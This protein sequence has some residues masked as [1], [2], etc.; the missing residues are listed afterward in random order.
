MHLH[1]REMWIEFLDPDS[2]APGGPGD[3]GEVVVTQLGERAMPLLRYAPG[4]VFR[5][6]GEPCTCGDPSPRIAFVGQVGGIRKIKGVLVHPAQ[7][8][9]ALSAFPELGNFQITV[10]HPA[11]ARYDR[12]VIRIA[13]DTPSPD[14]AARVRERLKANV[15]IQMDV[16]LVPS[17]QM[18][19]NSEPVL[20]LRHEGTRDR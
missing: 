1:A 8:K 4:D 2:G 19:A 15:L 3:S 12:A 7:V 6:A 14:L 20:D 10:D 18:P 11:A 9:S 5:L 16:E 17:A 13:C